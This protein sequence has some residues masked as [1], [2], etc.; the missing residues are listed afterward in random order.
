MDVAGLVIGAVGMV[1][2]WNNCVQAFDVVA[3]GRRYGHD[4]EVIRVK[5]EVER[6]R[7]L[8]WG[9][10]VGLAQ[11]QKAD[12]NPVPLI[13]DRLNKENMRTTVL[14][15]LGCIEHIFK[16]SNALERKYGLKPES[17]RRGEDAISLTDISTEGNQFIL[18]SIFKHTYENLQKSA[19]NYSQNTPFKRKVTWAISDRSKFLALVGEIKGFNDSLVSLFP[20]VTHKANRAIHEE[21]DTS[22]EIRSLQLLQEAAADNHEDISDSASLRL[23][24]LGATVMTELDDIKPKAGEAAAPVPHEARDKGQDQ[25]KEELD[26]E[27]IGLEKELDLVEKFVAERRQG[28]ITCY[29]HM[30]DWSPRYSV[31]VYWQGDRHEGFSE[32]FNDELKGF[33]PSLHSSFGMH[34]PVSNHPLIIHTDMDS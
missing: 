26:N 11:V 25:D 24:N 31:S 32:T 9:E 5:L 8:A 17:L 15:L 16:D 27:K 30:S 10:A 6:I 2:L 34:S 4:Y 28:S 19:K 3:A 14:R 21:I 33:V 7:L 12:S 13:D 20:D 1:A 22:D 23:N 18:G 29:M